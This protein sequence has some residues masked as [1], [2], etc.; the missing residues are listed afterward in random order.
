MI[1]A[2]EHIVI[3]PMLPT[4]RAFVLST[5]IQSEKSPKYRVPIIENHVK[6]DRV[7]VACSSESP[8]TI[9]AWICYHHEPRFPVYAY[10]SLG[11]R[12]SG[13]FRALKEEAGLL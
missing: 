12:K 5:W 9:Y 3:R 6:S 7:L 1:V 10:T 8:D 2:G 13:L 11:L 4:D